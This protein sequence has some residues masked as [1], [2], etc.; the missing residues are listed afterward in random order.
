MY[1][2]L[3][4]P[5]T[6]LQ[7]PKNSNIEDIR[8][9][10]IRLSLYYHPDR[11]IHCSKKKQEECKTKFQ[12]ISCAYQKCT[13]EKDQLNTT[14]NTS[15]DFYCDYFTKIL[16]KYN[17]ENKTLYDILEHIEL[18]KAIKNILS[19]L[20]GMVSNR[21][22]DTE[23]SCNIF[24]V[25]ITLEEYYYH[26]YKHIHIPNTNNIVRIDLDCIEQE[27]V[28]HDSSTVYIILKDIPH[29]HFKRVKG[30][31]LYHKISIDI[32]QFKNG[33][34]YELHKLDGTTQYLKFN[35]PY[36]YS[37]LYIVHNEGLKDYS[38]NH[39]GNLY[40]SLEIKETKNT[41]VI[42]GSLCA[43]TPIPLDIVNMLLN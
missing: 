5:Y 12:E 28:L 14:F 18:D 17:L 30:Y 27:I 40:I 10:Y 43:I 3:M 35:T 24:N 42:N 33:F 2:F 36:K 19:G 22:R 20:T 38:N 32:E 26:R 39:M 9:S 11:N 29:I 6:I 34:N 37:Q 15:S 13:E 16:K 41:K 1:N 31:D 21:N 25:S 23:N 4:D 8:K 7:I